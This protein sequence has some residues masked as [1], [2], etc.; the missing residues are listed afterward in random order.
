MSA[1]DP[2]STAKRHRARSEAALEIG[3]YP[4]AE[5]EARAALAAVPR[6]VDAM[7][8]L[9]RA[10]LGQSRHDEAEAAARSAVEA[11]PADGYT[12]YLLGF[13]MQV[14]GRHAEAVGPLREAV[15]LLPRAPRYGA[16]LA[17]ALCESGAKDEARL[18]IEGVAALG[19]EDPA[20]IDECARVF[21]VLA[22]H[23]RAE[24]FARRAV[25]MRP[26][27]PS[28]HWRLSWVLANQRRFDS[29]AAAA[30][31]AIELD[32]NYWA[33][34]EELGYSLFEQRVE[35]DAEA[36][37]A[38][39]LRLKPGLRSAAF[40]LAALYRRQGRLARAERVCDE[41]LQI[42]PSY[43]QLQR[44][45][46]GVREDLA[47]SARVVRDRVTALL[48]IAALAGLSAVNARTTSSFAVAIGVAIGATLLALANARPAPPDDSPPPTPTLLARRA[49][50]ERAPL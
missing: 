39:A 27:D 28:T 18:I 42:D 44:V 17:I 8:F 20:L 15:A 41:A 3:R 22:Q 5:R 1:T 45:R 12:H 46:Q 10:L 26:N 24:Q 31:A 7:L 9:A 6:D 30:T 50:T 36:A 23:E 13:I 47:A 4:I 34:W 25:V 14:T 48:T 38:E 35:S 19:I 40:N 21:S 37:L 11:A 49:S 2:Q 32:P 33:A 16:R 29:C 43:E